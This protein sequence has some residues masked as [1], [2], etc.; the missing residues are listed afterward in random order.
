MDDGR[1]GG[2]S[3]GEGAVDAAAGLRPEGV[4]V[5]KGA[6]GGTPSGTRGRRRASRPCRA[7]GRRGRSACRAGVGLEAAHPRGAHPGPGH[8]L[9]AGPGRR[10]GL[11]LGEDGGD[12]T[13]VYP[14]RL[15]GRRGEADEVEAVERSAG[16]VE[17]ADEVGERVA[18][19]VAGGGGERVA[20]PVQ[21]RI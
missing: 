14:A 2:R 6:G 7:G 9:Q 16:A 12:V 11:E 20:P 17:D 15:R 18:A 13:A 8:Q 10:A 21:L 4:G 5:E 19:V 3:V 1:R